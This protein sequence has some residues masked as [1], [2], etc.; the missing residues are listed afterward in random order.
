VLFGNIKATH[1][2]SELEGASADVNM[3]TGISQVFPAAG[4]RV[5][6]L[7]VHQNAPSAPAPATGKP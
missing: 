5:R 1:G 3:V 2:E 6:G 4:Q 7:F